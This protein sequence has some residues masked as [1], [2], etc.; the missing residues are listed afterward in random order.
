MIDNK[1]VETKLKDIYQDS[2]KRIP[3]S[4]IYKKP[5]LNCLQKIISQENTYLIPSNGE[6]SDFVD[7]AM[8]LGFENEALARTGEDSLQSIVSDQLYSAMQNVRDARGTVEQVNSVSPSEQN[9]VSIDVMPKE[10]I[11]RAS[12]EELYK[13]SIKYG[14][15]FATQHSTPDSM[16]AIGMISMFDKTLV[17]TTYFTHG[18]SS[19]STYSGN[20]PI[21][22]TISPSSYLF[23]SFL[24][25]FFFA[26]S[27]FKYLRPLQPFVYFEGF[28]LS[29]FINANIWP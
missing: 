17:I 24:L 26:C 28:W 14:E 1:Q 11:E 10:R 21:P 3:D 4:D 5:F 6:F 22:V 9:I 16:P 7:T 13:S 12:L 20:V 25:L 15:L 29:I 2:T 27:F 8:Q 23:I 18:P 19:F